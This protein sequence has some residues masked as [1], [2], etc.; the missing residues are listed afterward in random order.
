MLLCASITRHFIIMKLPFHILVHTRAH[1]A[2]PARRSRVRYK[3]Q[4][5]KGRISWT[6]LCDPERLEEQTDTWIYL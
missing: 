4:S 1:P 5:Q 6:I 2:H 3:E